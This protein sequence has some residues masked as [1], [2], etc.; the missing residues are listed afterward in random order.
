MRMK[1]LHTSDL[2]A[3]LAWLEWIERNASNF[4]LVCLAGD[5]LDGGQPDTTADQMREIFARMGRI[6]TPVAVCS[7]NHDMVHATDCD[8][9][10]GLWVRDLRRTGVHSD[11][12][13]FTRG[14]WR[15][16]CH[17]WVLPL[18]AATDGDIWI[19]HSPPESTAT[20]RVEGGDFDHGDFE[21]AEMCKA[22]RGPSIA[23]CGHIHHPIAWHATLGRTLIFNPGHSSDPQ[24]PAHIVI[25]L[26]GQTATRHLPG[27]GSE[28]IRLSPHPTGP[29]I[30]KRTAS[31]IESLLSLTISNQRAE[32]IRM[33]PEEIEEVRRRVMRLLHE[34]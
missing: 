6:S 34:E 14:R 22:G 31:E 29:M 32:G 18:P 15:F 26:D 16:Y 4:D 2:H 27:R 24:V 28:T 7:G 10:S 20:S 9:P 1:I 8:E 3:N 33:T 12:D 19:V 21:F 25:D 5:L 17:P 11:G 23:F 30:R 13:T